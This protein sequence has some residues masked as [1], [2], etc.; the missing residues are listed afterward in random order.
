MF[1]R[2]REID[3]LHDLFTVRQELE[4]LSVQVQLQLLLHFATRDIFLV[5]EPNPILDDYY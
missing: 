3:D 1:T 2:M 4:E 5:S